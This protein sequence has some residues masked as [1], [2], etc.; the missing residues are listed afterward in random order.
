MKSLYFLNRNKS[1]GNTK[2]SQ[3]AYQ[4]ELGRDEK[5]NFEK[6]LLIEPHTCGCC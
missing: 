5:C 3:T 1:E 6:I 2:N 4:E